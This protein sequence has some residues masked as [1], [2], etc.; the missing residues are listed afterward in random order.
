M[1]AVKGYEITWRSTFGRKRIFHFE[2]ITKCE[3]KKGSMRV[4]VDGKKLFTIDSNIDREEFMEDIKRRKIPVRRSGETN[5]TQ[6]KR[7]HGLN[8]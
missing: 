6:I 4:Y 8:S 2:D 7:N 3:R 5:R 1:E